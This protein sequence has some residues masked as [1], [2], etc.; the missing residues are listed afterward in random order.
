MKASGKVT[1]SGIMAKLE[2]VGVK[3]DRKTVSKY[4]KQF[5]E[6]DRKK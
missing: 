2:E 5:E 1:V 4:V 3:V 6:E